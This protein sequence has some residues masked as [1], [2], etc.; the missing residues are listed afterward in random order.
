M[1]D[2]ELWYANGGPLVY[3]DAEVGWYDAY[4]LLPTN[5]ALVAQAYVIEAPVH[6]WEVVRKID[7]DSAVSGGDLARIFM[8]MGA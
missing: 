1:A 3:D 7:L 5:G 6:D 8:L 4:P 2:K